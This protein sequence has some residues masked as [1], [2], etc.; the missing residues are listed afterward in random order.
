MS[1]GLLERRRQKNITL[2]KKN[3]KLAQFRVKFVGYMASKN[4]I[5]VN[6]EPIL[7][8]ETSY[9]SRSEKPYEFGKSIS[10]V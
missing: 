5:E 8:F 6:P 10:P 9:T 4:G 1:R 7:N 3:L 2:D